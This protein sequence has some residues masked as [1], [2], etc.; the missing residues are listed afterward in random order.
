MPVG[1]VIT[2]PSSTLPEWMT[3]GDYL[4]CNG[5]VFDTSK[6]PRLYKALGDNHV[7][8]Y[9]GVFLRGYGSR[10]YSST[11]DFFHAGI[12]TTV[13]SGELNVIQSDAGRNLKGG[14][15][16]LRENGNKYDAYSA[17][18]NNRDNCMYWY[19]NDAVAYSEVFNRGWS[20]AFFPR[21]FY[22]YSLVG[23]KESGYHLI[24]EQYFP[25]ESAYDRYSWGGAHVHNIDASRQWPTAQEFRPV[26]IAVRYFIKAR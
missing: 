26:N 9:R 8:D 22:K 3:H 11:L 12:S 20:H 5:Q 19:D 2:W 14:T 7:P 15:S 24:E 1:S 23:D 13:S 4:E 18:Y 17:V 25:T 10:T 16:A 21:G 6:Y